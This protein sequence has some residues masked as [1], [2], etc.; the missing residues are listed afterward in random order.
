[1]ESRAKKNK[2][3]KRQL[4]EHQF[5]KLTKFHVSTEVSAGT[6]DRDRRT[7]PTP[8]LS[9]VHNFPSFVLSLFDVRRS[10]GFFVLFHQ[11][12][13][14]AAGYFL[15]F[16]SIPPKTACGGLFSF[17]RSILVSTSHFF[18]RF[19]RSESVRRSTVAIGGTSRSLSRCAPLLRR[20]CNEIIPSSNFIFPKFIP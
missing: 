20:R 16:R 5:M 18:E 14:P 6:P 4:K 9:F 2:D 8:N 15:L 12:N 10:G 11:K 19:V 1:M 7:S 13:P 17:F 3:F